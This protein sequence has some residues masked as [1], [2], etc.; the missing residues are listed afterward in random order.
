MITLNIDKNTALVL[1][2]ETI[3]TIDNST[4]GIMNANK[5][6]KTTKNIINLTDIL[7]NFVIFN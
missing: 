6:D 1:P 5:N 3:V 2:K 4:N 7:E